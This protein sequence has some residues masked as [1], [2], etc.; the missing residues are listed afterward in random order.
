MGCM[1][2]FGD[3][4]NYINGTEY[5]NQLFAYVATQLEVEC[6]VYSPLTIL[7]QVE[8]LKDFTI[9]SKLLCQNMYKNVFNW[10]HVTL[11]ACAAY[12]FLPNKY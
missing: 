3:L 11:V 9:S 10:D 5:K 6:M 7:N 2:N 8:K 12:N 1:L 4:K